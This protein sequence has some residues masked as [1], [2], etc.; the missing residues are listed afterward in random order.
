MCGNTNESEDASV[1]PGK[2][3][4]FFLTCISYPGIGLPGDREEAMAKHLVFRVS[5][6]LT[7]ALEN[8]DERFIRT[9]VR[10]HN[11]IRSPRLAASS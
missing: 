8:S 10:T 7:T 9:L 2:S 4:L 6:A 1:C 5:C 3:S 11:R